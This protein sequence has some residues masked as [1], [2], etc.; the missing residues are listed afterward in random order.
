MNEA[1]ISDMLTLCA[2]PRVFKHSY[3]PSAW[4]LWSLQTIHHDYLMW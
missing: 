3:K 4:R 1:V 2:V